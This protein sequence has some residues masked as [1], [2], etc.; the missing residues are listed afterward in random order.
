MK[1]QGSAL[2]LVLFALIAVLVAAGVGW[3]VFKNSSLQPQSVQIAKTTPLPEDSAEP[4]ISPSPSPSYA[5][6]FEANTQ[7]S[8]PF[9]SKDENPFNNLE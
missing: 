1:Q 3:L 6:P 9:D 4:I 2:I 5:N 7:Y 8:N